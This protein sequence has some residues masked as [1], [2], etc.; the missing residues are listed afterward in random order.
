MDFYRVYHVDVEG[1]T[2]GHQNFQAKDD[3][4]ACNNALL[5]QKAG[6]WP[7]MELWV[8]IREAECPAD[9]IGERGKPWGLRIDP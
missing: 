7:I 5:I 9:R 2:V 8:N 4:A 1:K 3:H 6:K